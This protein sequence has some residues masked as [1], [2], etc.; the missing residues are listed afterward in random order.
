MVQKPATAASIL[1]AAAAS[2][3]RASN[4]A[5][6]VAPNAGR[7]CASVREGSLRM[8]A[9]QKFEIYYVGASKLWAAR[10]LKYQA[11]H[12]VGPTPP[13]ALRNLIAQMDKAQ[14]R[15]IKVEL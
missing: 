4:T 15:G 11:F 1:F 10:Y 7:N 6:A 8:G 9:K 5:E 12:A 13:E 2:H 3:P 14:Q